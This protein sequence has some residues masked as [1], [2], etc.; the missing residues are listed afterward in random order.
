M[1]EAGATVGGGA[2]IVELIPL[3]IY[4]VSV[5]FTG[6]SLA[7]L[8]KTAQGRLGNTFAITFLNIWTKK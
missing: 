1:T 8:H 6:R 3:E 7:P 2:A 5:E 4:S